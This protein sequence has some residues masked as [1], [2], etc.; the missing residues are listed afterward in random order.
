MDILVVIISSIVVAAGVGGGIYFGMSSKKGGK[1][2]QSASI[3]AV[4]DHALV[5]EARAKAREM[6]LEAR[7]NAFKAKSAA[8]DE[9]RKI[10]ETSMNLERDMTVKK[11]EIEAKEKEVSN[12]ART[13]KAAKERIEAKEEELTTLFKKQQTLLEEVSSLTKEEARKLLLQNLDKELADEKGRR[14]KSIEEDIKK[15]SQDLAKEIVLDAMRYD[16]RD[17]VIEYTTSRVNI[18]DDDVKGRI[19]GKEGRNIKKFEELTGVSLDLD[20]SPG[21]VV[22][23]CFD[24]VRRE[25]AKISLEKL[26]NDGRIQPTKIE[27]VVEKTH[28]E[29]T[30]IIYKAGDDLCHKAGIYNVPKELVQY[31]GRFKY[32]FSYGQNMLSHTMEVV[33]LGAAIAH[34]L[35]LDIDT[36]KLGCLYHD[37]GKII[38]DQEGDHVTLGVELLKKFK[39]P[40]KAIA[41]VAEHH[42]DN[43]SSPESVVV[44]MADQMSGARP[45]SRSEDYESYVQRLKDLEEAALSFDGVE[46]AYAVSAG[47]EVRVFVSPDRVDDPSTALLAREIAKKIELEQT[48]PGTV[49]VIVI[50]EKRVI[51]TAR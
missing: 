5:A 24:P 33:R 42:G 22:I 2:D 26:L 3:K 49:K 43:Y 10:K 30:H 1:V 13:L 34:E 19:I 40:E 11:A 45:G 16:A 37:I 35:K 32:R 36:V 23:S 47:R 9:V 51:E 28:E 12:N 20:S 6:I 38:S 41:C 31:L 4:D 27:E 7:D 15:K 50:R 17:I 39:V 48:Y 29:L 18:T 8:E 25:V 44:A 21:Q 14:I 46:K